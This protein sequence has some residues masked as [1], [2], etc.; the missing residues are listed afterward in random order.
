IVP[1]GNTGEFYS[2]SLKECE[3]VTKVVLDELDESVS[4]LVGVGYNLETAI[5][6]SKFAEGNGADGVMIHQP[7]HPHITEQ[8]LIDYYNQIAESVNIGVVLYVKSNDLSIEGFRELSRVKNIVGI[9]YSVK[10]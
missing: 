5:K 3:L 8:G 7:I 1:C 10:D 2:L 6:Q 4:G 9:K